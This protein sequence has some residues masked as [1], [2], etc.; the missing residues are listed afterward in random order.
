MPDSESQAT[1]SEI[2]F[3]TLSSESCS[4][5]HRFL[6]IKLCTIDRSD[7]SI[8]RLKD[9]RWRNDDARAAKDPLNLAIRLIEE[10]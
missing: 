9:G 6:L 10:T 4:G 7:R 1:A 5:R 2:H 3:P 8:R